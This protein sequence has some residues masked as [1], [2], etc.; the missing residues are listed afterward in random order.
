MTLNATRKKEVKKTAVAAAELI[1]H[2]ACAAIHLS[3]PF[4]QSCQPCTARMDL[5]NPKGGGGGIVF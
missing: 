3:A 1:S 2:S 4:N 5:L